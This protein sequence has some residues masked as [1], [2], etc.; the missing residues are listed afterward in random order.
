MAAAAFDGNGG[1][2]YGYAIDE[3][4]MEIDISGGVWLRRVSAFD[5]GYG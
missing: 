2:G 3:V 5:S 1:G 4:T